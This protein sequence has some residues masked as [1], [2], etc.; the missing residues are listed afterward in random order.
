MARSEPIGESHVARHSGV[1]VGNDNALV[2]AV[3]R[4]PWRVR[5]KLLLAFV[6]IVAMFVVVGILGLRTLSQSNARVEQL[7]TLQL[8][9]AAYRELQTGAAQLRQL[10]ALRAGG[11]ITVYI[12]GQK[13]TAPTRANRTFL[14]QTIATTLLR[15]GPATDSSSLGF[16]PSKADAPILAHIRMDYLQVSRVLDRIIAF[17]EVG[18]VAR[19]QKLQHARAEPLANELGALASRLSGATQ[20]ETTAL[21]AQNQSSF[22][23]SRRIFIVAGVASV[24]LA[25]LLGSVLAWSVVGPIQKTEER[26]AEIASGDFSRHLDVPNRDELGTLAANLNLMNDELG[27][28]YEQLES[29]ATELASWN[30]TLE[31]RVD[32]QVKELRASRSRVVLAADAERRRIERDLHDGAQQHLIGLAL[33]L[34]LARELVSS[35][36][37]KANGILEGLDSEIQETLDRL[38][39]LAHGI[40]PPLLQDRG[41]TDALAAAALRAPIAAR[42]EA[43]GLGRYPPDVEATV[44]FCCLEALQNAA[45]HAGDGA[46]VTIRVRAD[47]GGD[48]FFDV[49]D[50][51]SGFDTGIGGLAGVGVTNMRDRV[52]AI[53]GSLTIA[54][55]PGGGTTVSGSL[56]LGD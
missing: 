29:Q 51:G 23:N 52:G 8:R 43:Q 35:E 24:V 21:I 22:S 39:D 38:R 13:P 54:S 25:L 3:A 6:G 28:L 20:A 26:L 2:R 18:A 14:D 53:G 45:K 1:L 40:Y 15:L 55:S 19:G 17:D 46:S 56:P 9:A 10:L 11:D 33:Q 44:Y 36:P 42:V 32:D 30:R 50:D 48:L 5:S 7:G 4:M 12:G 49:T 34:R 31:A 41:L 27:R 47:D 16:A 37:E